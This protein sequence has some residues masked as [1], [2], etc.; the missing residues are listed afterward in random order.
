MQRPQTKPAS[1]S[2]K[3]ESSH[4]RKGDSKIRNTQQVYGTSAVDA[5]IPESI[6]DPEQRELA[7]VVNWSTLAGLLSLLLWTLGQFVGATPNHSSVLVL[8]FSA[9]LL[10]IPPLVIGIFKA[11]TAAAHLLLA[12]GLAI[13]VV[14]A[15]LDNGLLSVGAQF[16][17]SIPLIG[18]VL[19]SGRS[20]MVWIG[21]TLL[22]TAML[23]AVSFTQP[24]STPSN[25]TATSSL[26]NLVIQLGLYCGLVMITLDRRDKALA[27]ARTARAA[28]ERSAEARQQ[29]LAVT[30]HEL[31]TPLNGMLASLELLRP[32]L[33][34][35]ESL[36]LHELAVRSGETLR[37]LVEDILV[38]SRLSAGKLQPEQV[39]FHLRPLLHDLQRLFRP[40]ADRKGVELRIIADPAIPAVW[41]GDPRRLSQVLT[42]LLGN[43]L[44]FTTKGHVELRAV[45][46]PEGLQFSVS[47]TGPGMTQELTEELFQPFVQADASTSRRHGGSGLGLAIARQLIQAMNGTL[48]VTTSVGEGS[49][50]TVGLPLRSDATMADYDDEPTNTR[51]VL[52]PGP[53]QVLVVEDNPVNRRVLEL[54]LTELGSEVTTAAGGA[55]GAEAALVKQ[56]DLILMDCRMPEVDGFEATLRI[57]NAGVI[58]PIV[59]VTASATPE[60]RAQ[61]IECGM[62]GVLEKPVSQDAVRGLLVRWV[63]LGQHGRGLER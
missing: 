9:W 38:H 32:Q 29:T 49:T 54:M 18:L 39:P 3:R 36:E 61:C 27:Y 55:E 24:V 37:T 53:S 12:I 14:P 28:A 41:R 20:A 33:E 15:S 51:M 10:L 30:S 17:P 13:I 42:N 34:A 40:E 48:E 60:E 46:T 23:Y 63:G 58:V 50:F 19:L 2:N 56:W 25:L 26:L 43:A 44:K 45:T 4:S 21:V 59:A 7:R 6:S 31:R 5:L 1:S 22:S 62:D 16:I 8:L 57:R 52:T 47:D 11:P 35:P